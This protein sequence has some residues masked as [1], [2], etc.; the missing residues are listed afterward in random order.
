MDPADPAPTRRLWHTRL[1]QRVSPRGYRQVTLLTVWALGF[2]M[3]SGAAVRLTGSGLGCSDWPTCTKTSLVSP[4]QFH[5]VIEFGNRL[6]TALVTAAIAL[7]VLGSVRRTLRRRD[8]DL[9]SCG[10]VVGLAAQIVLGGETVRHGLAPQYVAAH[11]LLSLVLLADAVVL[12]HRAGW[13]D[14]PVAGSGA[15][16]RRPRRAEAATRAA[17]VSRAQVGL[18]RL[19]IVAAAVVVTLG[20]VVTGSGPHAGAPGVK[21]FGFTVHDAAKVHASSVWVFC[22]L[23]V[24][25]LWSV[26][27]GGAQQEVLKRAELLLVM[28]V[29]QG[30]LGYLQYLT[31]V[32]PFLVELH[33]VGAVGIWIVTLNFALG[34][35]EPVLAAGSVPAAAVA[36]SDDLTRSRSSSPALTSR[37]SVSP[38]LGS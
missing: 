7:A 19:L 15:E 31:G 18:S 12:H 25:T 21:R 3:V 36:G 9:L 23:A 17:T 26:T 10:L 32:P 14:H 16:S 4:W 1:T 11:F 5:A 35:F 28:I 30:G 13:P 37:A 24:L 29:A 38:P 22:F 20:T 8:L 2:I 6:V 34:L 33:V 27:R